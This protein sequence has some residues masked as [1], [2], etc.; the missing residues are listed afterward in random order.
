MHFQPSFD[1]PELCVIDACA[2]LYRARA[3]FILPFLLQ[4]CLP[5]LNQFSLLRKT[6][7]H[8]NTKF[9]VLN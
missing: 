3:F 6:V 8:N 1:A 7:I 4:D 2:L 9:L 5:Y